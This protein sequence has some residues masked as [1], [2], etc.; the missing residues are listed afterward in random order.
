MRRAFVILAVLVLLAAGVLAWWRFSSGNG[1][2]AFR[3]AEVRRADILSAI[4]ATG[5]L[6]PEEI[7]D[8]GAQVAG[9]ILS[10]GTDA[11]GKPV[12]YGSTVTE[13]SV[14]ATIDDTLFKADLAQAE[15]QVESAKAGVQ[16]AEADLG[17]L[18]ARLDQAQRDWD[19]AQRLGPGDLVAQNAYDAF[20]SAYD[21]AR[22]SVAVGEAAVVQAKA[23]VP[24]AEASLLRARRNLSFCVIRSPVDGV[25]IDRRVNI[26]Q[27]VVS[28][29]NAPSLFL[30]AKDLR[31][32]E[33][34]A[35]VNEADISSV[36]EGQ[37]ATFTVDAFPGRTFN[38]EVQKVRLNAAMTQNVVTYT[39][40]I[41]ADNSDS[42]LLPYLTANVSFIIDQK[43]DVLTVPNA[44]LRWMPAPDQ[45]EPGS[46]AE[47]P[48][49][50]PAPASDA[51]PAPNGQGGE[52]RIRGPRRGPGGGQ[53]LR[54]ST[55]TV[56]VAAG[57]YARPLKVTI[58]LS[59]GT[60]TEVSGP[61]L[62]EG[63]QVIVGEEIE[64]AASAAPGT[65]NPFA[66]QFNRRGMGGGGGGR[67][68]R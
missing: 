48:A 55:G 16:R 21:A 50:A 10:F 51:A 52:R 47:A 36:R 59:D 34:W 18:K 8:V 58:G 64:G 40:E 44:A 46:A 24:L 66:P 65:T 54:P 23:G 29:L 33:V 25:V 67:G 53:G 2:T 6:Q 9:M 17:Q 13:G 56:W 12:D 30:L 38:A 3:L 26:G 43:D 37:P 49:P 63:V 45:V 42:T 60:S 27:T 28:S 61:D 5:T 35:A 14:L 31:R 20:K 15:A 41:A 7:V 19:R 22:S 32:M 62:S 4:N 11:E 1:G 39:V 57:A 68:G